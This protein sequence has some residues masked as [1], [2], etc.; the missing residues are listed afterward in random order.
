MDQYLF[1]LALSQIEGPRPPLPDFALFPLDTHPVDPANAPLLA[2]EDIA[3]YEG[4][5]RR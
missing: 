3:A 1:T 4:A 2:F 5:D